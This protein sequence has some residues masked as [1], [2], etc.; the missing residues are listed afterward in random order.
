MQLL[1][2]LLISY[3]LQQ[4]IFRK[5]LIV[6]HQQMCMLPIS[7]PIPSYSVPSRFKSAT[8]FYIKIRPFAREFLETISPYYE[9]YLYSVRLL[10]LFLLIFQQGRRY[11]IDEC[12]KRLDPDHSF[13][14]NRIIARGEAYNRIQD[15][16]LNIKIKDMRTIWNCF[17]YIVLPLIV[18]YSY[19]EWLLTIQ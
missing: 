5:R 19:R 14:G 8:A 12:L 15:F 16:Y 11:Y 7:L 3:R 10:F 6:S 2:S 4:A 17:Q 1:L 18:V 9:L 13:F